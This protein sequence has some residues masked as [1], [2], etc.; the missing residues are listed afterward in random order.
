[1]PWPTSERTIERPVGLDVLLHG[2]RDVAEAVA[3]AALLDGVEQRALGDVEQL[4]GD[5]ARRRR[6]AKVRAASATQPSLTTPMSTE[7]MSPRGELELAR[8]A[9]HDHVVRRGADRARE[10]AV[11]LEGRRRAL[12]ADELL[13]GLVELQR[14]DAGADLARQQVH[15]SHEDLARRG[16]LVDLGR[17]LLDDHS[18]SFEAQRRERRADVVVHLRLVP[19]AVEAA[20]QPA[21]LVVVHQR[22]GLLVVGRRGAWRPSRARRPCA[23]TSGL[24]SWSQTS[25]VLGRVELD[26]VEV[27]VGALAAARQA[28]QHDLVGRVDRA[29]P[30]SAAG[31]ASRAPRS[32]ASAWPTVRGKPSSRKPSSPSSSIL[33]RIIAMTSSSGTRSPL[34]MY[35]LALTP[36][37]VLVLLVLAQQVAGAD[38]GQPEVLAQARGL[39]A[40]TG[41]GRT[42]EDEVQLAHRRLLQEAFV[43]AHH[44]LRLELLH[45]VEG[46]ADHDQERRAAEVEV[47]RSVWLGDDDGRERRDGRQVQGSRERQAREDAV[48]ELG[49]RAPWPH[50]GDEAA[51]LLAGCPPGRPG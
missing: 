51:V 33:S 6:P 26:V 41:P 2:V 44:Q 29:A 40:L 7:R 18:R 47:R 13:G 17:G 16:H 36:S 9:V 48:Q 23:G 27:P 30:R 10:A 8:D 15:G 34:S 49:R 42:E 21:L 31:R 22:L 4:R 24:P 5:R 46:H 11:A 14:G 39:G 50:A 35:S 25:V 37:S 38:V 3:D 32:S 20:Q 1:M 19:R 43:V 45:G 28:L 12:G